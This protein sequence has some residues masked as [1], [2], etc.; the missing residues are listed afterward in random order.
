VGTKINHC[1]VLAGEP[2]IGKDTLLAPLVEGV[3]VWNF[4]NI[5]PSD[6]IANFT[7]YYETLLLRIN[8]VQNLGNDLNRFKFYESSKTML[9]T[10]PDI[11]MVNQ[12]YMPRYPV[13]NV[14][15][16]IMTTNHAIDGLYLPANDRRY[17]VA[18]TD[19]TKEELGGDAYFKSLWGYLNSGGM[20]DVCEY[21][22][23]VVDLSDFDAKAPPR[24][25]PAF[26]RIVQSAGDPVEAELSDAIDRLGRPAALTLDDLRKA[27]VE[28]N[29]LVPQSELVVK[30]N[31]STKRRAIP[32]MLSR[33]GYASVDNPDAKDKHWV[34]GGRRA[35]VYANRD[36]T[37]AAQL[38]AAREM[39]RLRSANT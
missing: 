8:E 31:D 7:P 5:N 34:I 10:P 11:L 30:L 32:G 23:T 20:G 39:A 18:A 9:A 22:R 4:A 6:L 36:L 12:K 13:F 3:G 21:L 33:V 17:Y 27:V 25:T 28:S 1:I 38:S 26:C 35:A 24:H 15:N 14:L 16:C 29:Y 19:I 2:G 37:R